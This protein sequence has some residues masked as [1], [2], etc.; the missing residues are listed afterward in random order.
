MSTERKNRVISSFVT[1]AVLAIV[2]FLLFICGLSY[3]FPPPEAN[4]LI[5]VEFFPVEDGGGGGGGGGTGGGEYAIPRSSNRDIREN[6]DW[7]TQIADGDAPMVATNLNSTTPENEKVITLEPK[8]EPGATYKPGK[9]TGS[10]A[11]SGGGSG[12]GTGGGTGTGTGMG[13]GP[14]SGGGTGGGSGGGIGKGIGHGTGNRA[15]VNIPDVTIKENGVVYVEVHVTAQGTVNSARIISTAKYPT[16]IT[17]AQ[18]RQDCINRALQVKYVA[19]K[20]E[21]RIIVFK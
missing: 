14:G 5:L 18:V 20:E 15:Y 17:N 21:F 12:G 1:A 4:N 10:G 13:I 2:V 19:G 16:N 9:G 6:P 3:Q 7:A 11:G 8:P